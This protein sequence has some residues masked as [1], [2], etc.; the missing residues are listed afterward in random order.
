MQDT[1]P[2]QNGSRILIGSCHSQH[3]PESNIW[4]AM[5]QRNASTMIWAG[6]TIY[7]DDFHP[8]PTSL[9]SFSKSWWSKWNT[10]TTTASTTVR[11]ATPSVLQ[12]LYEQLVDDPRYSHFTRRISGNTTTTNNK[13]H[14][15]IPQQ[16]MTV[17]G[18]WDDHDYG[19]NNGDKTY[20]YRTE[21]AMLYLQFLQRSS[22]TPLDLHYMEQRASTGKGLY[23]VKV[24]DFYRPFGQELLSDTEAGIEPE[25]DADTQQQQLSDRS[26]AIFLIDCRSNKTPWNLKFPER[27]KLNYDADFLGEDQWEW[28]E[29]SMRRSTAAVN[30]IVQ[31]LQVH[32][33][34]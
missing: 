3:Y 9:G 28:L 24:L 32:A 29:A 34:H 14:R 30:L 22:S 27:Y 31:G 20:L 21:S 33:D 15:P 13:N 10:G 7:G 12:S 11:P 23:G 1:I 8:S 4:N 2:R 17:L 6:D 26:V 25:L 19:I 5:T 16:T 18:V